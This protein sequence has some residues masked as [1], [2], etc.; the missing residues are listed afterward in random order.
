MGYQA[1]S[2]RHRCQI[3]NRQLPKRKHQL[4]HE[5]NMCLKNAEQTTHE[6]NHTR[7]RDHLKSD[8]TRNLG[9]DHLSIGHPSI[10]RVNQEIR[11]RLDPRDP[12]DPLVNLRKPRIIHGQDKTDGPSAVRITQ[13]TNRINQEQ[14]D[15]Q[16][17][18]NDECETGTLSVKIKSSNYSTT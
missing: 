17:A 6:Q 16:M 2:R 10:N 4:H 13:I 18:T 8:H 11:D 9:I 3:I 5:F 15:H 7:N 14:T 12:L 1:I